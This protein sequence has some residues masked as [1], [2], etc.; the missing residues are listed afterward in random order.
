MALGG[1]R[2]ATTPE[3]RDRN[4]GEAETLA[5]GLAKAASRFAKNHSKMVTRFGGA[6]IFILLGTAAFTTTFGV[7]ADLASEAPLALLNMP[8]RSP[9]G[10]ASD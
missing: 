5:A 4:F 3:Q 7:S 2:L 1:A 8:S 6:T 9:T 10:E